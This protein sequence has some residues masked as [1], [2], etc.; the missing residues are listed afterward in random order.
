MTGSSSEQNAC[1]VEFEI[2]QLRALP[3][4]YYTDVDI[5]ERERERLFF[6]TWQYA[7]H[8]S[9]LENPGAYVATDIL[10][11][12]VFVVRNENGDINAFYNVCPR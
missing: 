11:Q 1:N 10:G 6:R 2:D 9:E 4:L 5:L 8:V 7:C 3:S 12:N